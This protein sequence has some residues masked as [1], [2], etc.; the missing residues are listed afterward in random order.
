MDT[1]LFW[2][3]KENKIK[4][5]G[6]KSKAWSE[7]DMENNVL[8]EESFVAHNSFIVGNNMVVCNGLALVWEF[9]TFLR[10]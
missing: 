2:E 8:Q 10:T 1:R 6:R 4:I 5:K 9:Q 3:I 7:K